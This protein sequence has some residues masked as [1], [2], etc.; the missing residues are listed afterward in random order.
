MHTAHAQSITN[1]G[2]NFDR[3]KMFRNAKSHTRWVKFLRIGLPSASLILFGLY[4]IPN[5]LEIKVELPQGGKI[6]IEDIEVKKDALVMRNPQYQGG[7]INVK[8]DHSIQNPKALHIL[9]LNKIIAKVD[10]KEKGWVH[11]D[12]AT[13]LLDTKKNT[14]QLEKRIDIKTHSGVFARLSHADVHMKKQTVVSNKP[15]TVRMPN[16]N[17]YAE[18]MTF[19]SKTDL[20]TFQQNVRVHME[21]KPSA[22]GSPKRG[23]GIGAMM[24][25]SEEPIK[26]TSNIL[27][28]NHKQQTAIFRGG[29]LAMQAG[30]AMQA[31]ALL[32]DYKSDG[33]RKSQGASLP[34]GNQQVNRIIAE[35][36]VVITTTEG[37]QARADR[38]IFDN[39]KQLVTLIDNVV[40]EQGDNVLKGKRM[41]IDLAKQHSYFP[42][43]QGRVQGTFKPKDDGK[44]KKAPAQTQVSA[45]NKDPFGQGFASFN[46]QSGEPFDISADSLSIY[47][48][49]KYAIFKG[50]VEVIRGQH[51]IRSGKMRIDYHGNASVSGPKTKG[52]S[53][54][55]AQLKQIVA[56]ERVFITTPDNQS[57]S[58]DKAV[59]NVKANTVTVSGNVAISQEKNLLKGDRIV[60]DLN[61]GLY[62]LTG[63]AQNNRNNATNNKQKKKTRTQMIFTPGSNSFNLPQQ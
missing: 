13:G 19:Y 17:V 57:M 33:K 34:G 38:S 32:I 50:K 16:G 28:I 58:G 22:G 60:V 43:G 42:P 41:V 11:M 59:F 30:L 5:K 47:D 40:I 46:T 48:R 56:S 53:N 21:N 51:K 37:Q 14:M 10:N 29:V 39:S 62:K 3:V 25:G 8:A 18:K 61:T 1:N 52:K 35:Q 6:G 45:Q 63:L 54:A 55:G 4:F 9:R 12:A 31:K 49:K 7:N 27:E 44:Q 26:V 23:G 24:K 36:D 15:V 2:A 20:L